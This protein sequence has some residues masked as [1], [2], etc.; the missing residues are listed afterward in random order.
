MGRCTTDCSLYIPDQPTRHDPV[1]CVHV[2]CC[3]LT[4]S[5]MCSSRA[6]DYAVKWSDLCT[7]LVCGPRKCTVVSVLTWSRMYR[8]WTGALWT[9]LWPCSCPV[10]RQLLT[11]IP[12]FEGFTPSEGV[13]RGCGGYEL[14][15]FDQYAAVSPKRCEVRQRLLLITNRKSNTRFRLVPK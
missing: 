8:S 2:V 12:K 3:I 15:I 5:G 13:E 10:K 14:A 9:V 4:G 7:G 11:I 1:L 6:G